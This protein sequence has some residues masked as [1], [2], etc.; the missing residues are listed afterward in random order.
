M[1]VVTRFAPSPTG[2]LHIGGART[3]IFNYLFAKKNSGKYLV[4]IED[5]DK[6]RSSKE[7][8]KAIHKGLNWLNVNSDYEIVYQSQNF[9]SHIK[10]AYELLEKG[11]AYKCFLNSDELEKLRIKSRKNGIPIKSP[12]RDKKKQEKYKNNEFVIRLKM[13]KYGTTTINDLVQGN[14][15]V[16]NEILDDMVILRS[17]NTPT[18]M[19]SS[20]VD[21]NDMGITHIIRGDDHFNNAFRQIQIIKYLNWNIPNY[22]HIPL[23]HGTDGAK[24]SKRHGATNLFDYHDLG[25]TSEAMFSY[26]LQLGWSSKNEEDYFIDRAT[27]LFTLEKINKSPAKFDLKKLNNINSKYL[28]RMKVEDIFN[29]VVNRF[30]LNLNNDEQKR[31]KS[32]LPAL[33]K[34]VQVY[35]DLENE[36]DW[37]FKNDFFC[38][39]KNYQLQLQTNVIALQEIGLQLKECEWNLENIK[40]CID[41][42]ILDNSLTFKD[43]G[44]MLRM[45]LT[46]KTNS[47]DII[48][49]IY[50]LGCTIT[51]N[52]LNYKY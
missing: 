9:D 8:I 4:R 25:Y 10:V 43:I 2:F 1:S 30:K 49:I 6:K 17:D 36:F 38:K 26:L 19:L 18:Y 3:A 50:E 21:D 11:F 12:W 32:L 48:T 20:V 27:K 42:Y 15:I 47:P 51:V 14:V 24:L 23:I 33:L 29:L 34:R 13:P 7:A 39:D 52:R 40:K 16:K 31:F 22:A 28:N 35:T 46:G 41:Q 37:L 45:A 44:P 5:T